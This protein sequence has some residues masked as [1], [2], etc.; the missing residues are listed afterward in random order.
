MSDSKPV[1]TII[2][3]SV[4][5]G[6]KGRAVADWFIAEAQKHGAFDVQIA[7]LKSIDLPLMTEPNHPRMKNYTQEKTWEWSRLIDGSDAFAFVMPEYNH[8]LSAPL[9]N[10]IDYLSQEWMHKPAA[11]VSYGGISGGQRAAQQLRT[12]LNALSIVAM[13]AQVALPSF[14]DHI[15]DG[16]FEAYESANSSAQGVLDALAKWHPALKTLRAE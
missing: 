13:P 8:S 7:D 3:A 5:D 16:V 4:R 11:I 10:A 14:T 9:A 2:V 6:R 1:L 12:R 15:K